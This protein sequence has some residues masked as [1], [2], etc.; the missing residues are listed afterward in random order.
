MAEA[1]PPTE[2]VGW[3]AAGLLIALAG[4]GTLGWSA[5]RGTRPVEGLQRGEAEWLVPAPAAAPEA[6]GP[7]QPAPV[8][9]PAQQ[10]EAPAA[11]P[12]AQIAGAE[13]KPAPVEPEALRI[14]INVATAAQLELLPGIGPTLAQRIVDDRALNGRFVV[15]EDLQRV[16]GIGPKTLEAVRDLIVCGP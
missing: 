9:Q 1:R 11:G 2:T 13:A 16:R 14:D 8:A 6:R 12:G 7:V 10:V 4:A 15:P 3:R 5:W